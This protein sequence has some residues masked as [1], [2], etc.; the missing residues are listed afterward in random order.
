[1]LSPI[2]LQEVFAQKTAHEILQERDDSL[3]TPIKMEYND[4]IL[5]V[6]Q[7]IEKLEYNVGENITVHCALVNIGSNSIIINHLTPLL[8]SSVTYSNGST[9]FPINYPTALIGGD[10]TIGPGNAVTDPNCRPS[11]DNYPIPASSIRINTP[12][13]YHITSFAYFTIHDNVAPTS[14]QSLWSKPVQIT[15]LPE[16][17]PEF[18][19]T[20]P[21][22]LTSF[23][24]VILFY[25]IRFRK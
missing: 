10:E 22:L 4:A 17:I 13:T 12:G 6:N 5:V 2:L 25:R 9:Y 3:V 20:I 8:Q 18:S 7:T 14:F 21:I 19:F 1:M 23:I 15:V 16:R 24:S 11:A